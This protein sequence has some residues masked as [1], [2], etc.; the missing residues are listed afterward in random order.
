M[1]WTHPST[2]TPGYLI[3]WDIN[4]IDTNTLER[5]QQIFLY[6]FPM[7]TTPIF[8]N[9]CV[10]YVRLYWFEKRFERIGLSPPPLCPSRLPSATSACSCQLPL[11][12]KSSHSVPGSRA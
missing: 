8:I 10:V 6:I 7:L 11:P 1:S 3:Y 12:V 5:Y 4:S 9:T 2:I